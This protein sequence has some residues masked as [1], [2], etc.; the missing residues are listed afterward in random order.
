MVVS[1]RFE[2]ETGDYVSGVNDAIKALKDWESQ[3]GVSALN[4]TDKFEEAIEA[5][6]YLGKVTDRSA[7]DIKDA[8][9]GI[10]L[11]AEDAEDA[12]RAVGD[13]TRDIGRSGPRDLDKLGEA[14]EDAGDKTATIKDKS[15]TAGEGL[16]S[17]G[18]IARDVL[19]GDF[20]GAIEGVGQMLGGLGGFIAGGAVAGAVASAIAGIVSNWIEQWNAANEDIKKSTADMWQSAA[21]DGRQFLDED[22]IT[23]EAHRILWDDNYKKI[24]DAAESAGVSRA[25]FAVIAAEGEGEAF[26]RVQEKIMTALDERRRALREAADEPGSSVNVDELNALSRTVDLLNE[27]RDA[28][29]RNKEISKD[30]AE[31]E[32]VLQ[33]QTRDGYQKTHDL[34]ASGYDSLSKKYGKPLSI[35]VVANT[36]GAR[37]AVDNL[38]HDINQRTARIRIGGSGSARQILGG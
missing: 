1:I 11:S 18:D 13:E 20:G 4:A 10:G 35:D 5:V 22:A 28:T 12:L 21:A 29:N 23:A 37:A 3:T 6:I 14:A 19:Q 7:G 34:I 27:K 24:L 32:Q 25:E 33:Q 9:Q 8:L 30:A 15:G 2:S 16:R 17:L 26:D 38:V 31:V 36:A